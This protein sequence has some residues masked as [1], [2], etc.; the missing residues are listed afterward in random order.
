VSVGFE[1][2]PQPD[3]QV[4]AAIVAALGEEARDQEASPWADRLLPGRPEAEEA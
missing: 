3:D 1:L 4:R 2:T